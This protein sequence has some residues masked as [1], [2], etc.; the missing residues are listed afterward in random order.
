MPE[1]VT[2]DGVAAARSLRALI[3]QESI[4]SE[5]KRTLSERTVTALWESGLM[6]WA[7]P[8]AAGGSEPSLAEMI[9]TWIEL[10]WQDGSL[11]WVGI[12]N[13]PSA[14]VCAAYLSDEGFKE[15]FSQ[16]DN[17]VTAGGS[18]EHGTSARARPTPSTSAPA[19]FRRWTAKCR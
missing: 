1:A 8:K 18:P 4:P 10:A 17:R 19:S 7:N 12:A 15:V 9:D 3:A 13:F 14:A 2:V 16:H 11:G 6:Q 5:H